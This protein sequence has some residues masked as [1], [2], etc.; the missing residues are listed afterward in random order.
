MEAEIPEVDSSCGRCW[1]LFP[2]NLPQASSLSLKIND[3]RAGIRSAR[4]GENI[5]RQG[6]ARHRSNDSVL[7]DAGGLPQM[8]L[9]GAQEKH[10]DEI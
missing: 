4:Q 8:S 3:F 2:V 6:K 9:A 5:A 7:M 10:W 1:F